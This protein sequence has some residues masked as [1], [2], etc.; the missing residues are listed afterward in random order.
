MTGLQGT[1]KLIGECPTISAINSKCSENTNCLTEEEENLLHSM[2]DTCRSLN[3]DEDSRNYHVCCENSTVKLESK[4]HTSE[5][6]LTESLVTKPS[7]LN[8]SSTEDSAL[9][10]FPIWCGTALRYQID[11]GI[12]TKMTKHPWLVALMYK[13]EK[14]N[15]LEV[16]CGGSMITSTFALTAA[17]CLKPKSPDYVRVGEQKISIEENCDFISKLVTVCKPKHLDVVVNEIFV[18]KDYKNSTMVL[19][20]DIGLI[21]TSE[22]IEF[23]SNQNI[24][25]VPLVLPVCLPSLND[26][27]T[28]EK[29][30]TDEMKTFEVSG[31]GKSFPL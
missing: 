2:K 17:H 31:W 19:S 23:N 11:V 21:R 22:I 24:K 25:T 27:E 18:H 7:I 10:H 30:I 26:Q 8:I 12:D 28:K 14:N 20:N 6:S 9:E 29:I 5:S 1:C 3:S 16:H 15:E 13:N 4:N